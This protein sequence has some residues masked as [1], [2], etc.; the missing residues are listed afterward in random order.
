MLIKVLNS[1]FIKCNKKEIPLVFD[2]GRMVYGSTDVMI[3]HLNNLKNDVKSHPWPQVYTLH[4]IPSHG[5]KFT[6]NFEMFG[7]FDSHVIDLS[8]LKPKKNDNSIVL[9]FEIK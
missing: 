5:Q 8:L 4:F 1:A 9:T 6:K 3:Y 7:N 2:Y